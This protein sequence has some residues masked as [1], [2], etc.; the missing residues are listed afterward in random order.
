MP[1]PPKNETFSFGLKLSDG[2]R[3]L[4]ALSNAFSKGCDTKGIITSTPA[5]TSAGD[6]GSQEGPNL[7]GSSAGARRRRLT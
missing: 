7:I 2:L 4:L 5:N 6:E 3:K 1:L